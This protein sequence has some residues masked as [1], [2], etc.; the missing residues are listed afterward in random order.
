MNPYEAV[1]KALMIVWGITGL[2]I[3]IGWRINKIFSRIKR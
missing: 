1:F 3:L 2:G